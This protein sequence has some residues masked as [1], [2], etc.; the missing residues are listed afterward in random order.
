MVNVM[1]AVTVV[2]AMQGVRVS[3]ATVLALLSLNGPISAEKL[4]IDT[5]LFWAN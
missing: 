2:L 3:A 4:E 5:K 1:T